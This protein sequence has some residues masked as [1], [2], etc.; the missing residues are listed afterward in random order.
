MGAG[1][2]L[3]DNDRWDWLITLRNEAIKYLH[4]SNSVIVTCSA[5]KRKYR[6]VIRV[7]NYEHPSV[8][9]HFVYLKVDEKTLQERVASRVGHYMKGNMVHSQMVAL[10]EPDDED[11]V[12][13]VD[14]TNDKET[15]QKS[16]L[17]L[18]QSKL[19]EYDDLVKQTS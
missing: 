15:V 12:L 17:D 9:I 13:K 7:A 2:P 14:V 1:T 11:D 5:L 6:D 16:A 3:N 8:Q 19:K 10:E 4:T 18:V